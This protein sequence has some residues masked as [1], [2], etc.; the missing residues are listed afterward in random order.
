MYRSVTG[1]RRHDSAMLLPL[2]NPPSAWSLPRLWALLFH[3]LGPPLPFTALLSFLSFCPRRAL[4][5]ASS[6]SWYFPVPQPGLCLGL[7]TSRA[8]GPDAGQE[9]HPGWPHLPLRSILWW[10]P[11]HC[12]VCP[13]RSYQGWES[14]F[15]PSFLGCEFPWTCP[16]LAFLNQPPRVGRGTGPRFPTA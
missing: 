13:Q 3:A 11:P 8:L 14:G 9:P 16:L 6:F 10:N 4:L 15:S 1:C 5:L 7:D 12:R 2:G